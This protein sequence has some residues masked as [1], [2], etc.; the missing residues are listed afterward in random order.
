M[1]SQPLRPNLRDLRRPSWK[2]CMVQVQANRTNLAVTWQLM[3]VN[4]FDDRV[5]ID[6]MTR[7]ALAIRLTLFE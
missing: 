3:H 2:A 7:V 4:N 5:L 1:R 6:C